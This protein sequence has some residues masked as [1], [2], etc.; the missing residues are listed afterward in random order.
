M[1]VNLHN[2]GTNQFT[3]YS[4]NSVTIGGQ[5]YQHNIIVTNNKIERCNILDINQLNY[6]DLESIISDAPDLIIFGTGNRIIYP[7]V[8][9]MQYLQSKNIGVEIMQ[10]PALC[11][12]FNFLVSEDR[13]VAC[14][15][16]FE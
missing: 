16:L 6:N 10:I 11:R 7:E 13:K 8:E 14:V 15:I 12:T 1:Q 2:V 4:T 5:E 3:S 9:I